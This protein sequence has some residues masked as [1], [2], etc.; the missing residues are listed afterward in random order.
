MEYHLNRCFDGKTEKYQL[1]FELCDVEGA[2]KTSFIRQNAQNIR[3]HDVGCF[4]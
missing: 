3:L 4:I 1:Y 2:Q